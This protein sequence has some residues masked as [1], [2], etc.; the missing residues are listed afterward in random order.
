MQSESGSSAGVSE[1]DIVAGKYRVERVLGIG[2][3]GVVGAAHHLQLD[4]TVALK[5]L[6]PDAFHNPEAVARFAREA[7]AT[8]KI[9]S[10]HVARVM[11]VGTLA[12]G[13]PYMVMEYL[14]GVDL[15]AWLRKRGP[16]PIEQAVEFVLQTCLALA[17]A[18]V[19]G[20]V[21]RDL[22]PANL[23]C[24]RRSDGQLAIKV[25]DFGIS[26]VTPAG[27]SAQEMW[28]TATKAVLGSPLYMSPEQ[29]ESAK[30]VDAQTDI[31]ALGVILFELVTGRAA[32]VGNSVVA[33]AIKVATEPPPAIQTLL[34]KAPSALDAIVFRCLKRNRGER[35]R[36]VAELA[37]DLLRLFRRARRHQSSGSAAS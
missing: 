22:K 23:F 7:R 20:I 21:H 10:E 24:I 31:W 29:M 3:M 16:L 14:D 33:L 36:N 5:F 26:K 1:G 4:Q 15:A 28:V 37:V 18:H 2:G 19:L 12:N 32:F 27:E 8:A 30:H 13:T 9:K 25:L 11:D 6:L 17:D 35:Y 34:A